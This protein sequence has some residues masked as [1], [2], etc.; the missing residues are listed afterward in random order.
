MCAACC[1]QKVDRTF[2][3]RWQQYQT[4]ATAAAAAQSVIT[5]LYP[6]RKMPS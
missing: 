6:V 1:E 2:L 4:L 5:P 3:Q